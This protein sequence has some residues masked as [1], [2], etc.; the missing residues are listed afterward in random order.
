MDAR[1]VPSREP[2]HVQMDKGHGRLERREIWVEP[3]Q[4]LGRYLA[5]EYGWVEVRFL[6]QVRRYRRPLHQEAWASVETVFWI[7]GGK[8][9][10]A[11]TPAQF[12]EQLRDHWAIENRVFYVRDVTMDEDHLHGRRIGPALSMLRNMALNCLR[13]LGLPYIPDARRA[14][15][16]QPRR[17]LYLLLQEPALEN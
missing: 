12:Q 6:G 8:G 9:L 14:V 3:A 10:A 17:G 5:Q 2:D 13:R 11:L 1:G 4:A 16:A 15:V 7:A